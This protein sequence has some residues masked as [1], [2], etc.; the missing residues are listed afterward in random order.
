M[1]LTTAYLQAHG[2]AAEFYDNSILFLSYTPLELLSADRRVAL[3][4]DMAVAA[5]VGDNVYNFGEVIEHPIM[6]C[7]EGT[8]RAW[9]RQMLTAFHLGK[10]DMFNMIVADN[11]DA[12]DEVW[13]GARGALKLSVLMWDTHR[14][15]C[16][17]MT[18]SSKR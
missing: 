16:C 9:L 1:M 4:N 13:C 3:A 11:R 10:I 8:P 2:P 12:W 14:L 15:P 17:T 6:D 5:L 7:L 18:S